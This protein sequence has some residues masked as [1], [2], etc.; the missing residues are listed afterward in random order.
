[1]S[2]RGHGQAMS[3]PDDS[4]PLTTPFS[5]PY[6]SSS[7][8]GWRPGCEPTDD[9][10]SGDGGGCGR[11]P[12]MELATLLERLGR[13]CSLACAGSTLWLYLHDEFLYVPWRL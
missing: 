8:L 3:A 11:R 2:T 13:G 7:S 6:G 5:P 10:D 12:A 4:W 1:M 9:G